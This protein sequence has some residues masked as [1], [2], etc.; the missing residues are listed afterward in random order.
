[1][2]AHHPT[3]SLIEHFVYDDAARTLLVTFR[4]GRRY[5]YQNVPRETYE[6]L[7]AARSTGRYFNAEIRDRFDGAPADGRR[8][9]PLDERAA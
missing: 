1:M 8:R 4:T 7:V 6:A 3:S 2:H 9:Y 5:L